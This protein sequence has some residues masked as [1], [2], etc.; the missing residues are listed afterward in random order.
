MPDFI[1]MD[2]C[3]L[4]ICFSN[5]NCL[6]QYSDRPNVLVLTLLHEFS[7]EFGALGAKMAVSG[8]RENDAGLLIMPLD[9]LQSDLCAYGN[10][11]ALKPGRQIVIYRNP[12][13][14]QCG[15]GDRYVGNN[16]NSFCHRA[17]ED[18][19]LSVLNVI[20]L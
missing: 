3:T 1:K 11:L 2:V 7:V 17:H 13:K 16:F 15:K 10:M 20:L 14:Y 6:R 5:T 12:Y 19:P 4:E 18:L 8:E 9:A